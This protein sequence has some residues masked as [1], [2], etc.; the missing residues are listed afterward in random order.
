MPQEHGTGLDHGRRV[1]IFAHAP[2]D[3]TGCRAVDGFKHS[4]LVADVGRASRTHAAL[5]LGSFVGDDIAVQVGQQDHLELLTQRIFQ[6]IGSHNIDVVIFH[7]NAGVILGNLMTEGSKLAVCLFH[8]IG[9]GDYGQVGLAVVLGI[10][11]GCPG[12]ALRT[13][14]GGNL[15]VHSHAVQIDAA[16]AQYVLAFR[17][18]PEEHPVDVLLRNG[19]RTAVGIQIQL[20]AHGNIGRFHGA[21]MGCGGGA[22]QDHVT[23]F[24]LGQHIGRNGLI[25][26]DAVF[27]GQAFD[28]LNDNRTCCH[29][30]RQNLLQN[31]GCLLG[32]N[33]ADAVAIHNANFH[34]LL[35][36]KVRLGSVHIGN[37]C[38][39]LFQNLSESL[40]GLIDIHHYCPPSLV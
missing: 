36:G 24:D 37:S 38:L 8:N 28:V 12:D 14:I 5:N 10:L 34:A 2:L 23:G 13:G 11:K 21:A 6:Q 31:P 16:A 18:L 1:C 20:P 26:G 25:A 9:L 39:L 33:R 29:F 35:V 4:V 7:R 22:L 32:N 17:I 15:E 40:T 3:H 19:N 27:D 30:I